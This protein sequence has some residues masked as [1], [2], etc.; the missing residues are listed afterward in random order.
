MLNLP[1]LMFRVLIFLLSAGLALTLGLP[2]KSQPTAL[3]LALEAQQLDRAGDLTQAAI[4]WQEAAS[5]FATEG[6]VQGRTKSLIN[7]SQVLQELGQ[8][9]RA[10][11]T[12][13][14][15]FDLENS[16]C[17]QTEQLDRFIQQYTERNSF[18]IVEGIGLRSLGNI[19]LHQGKLERSQKLL[20]LSVTAT[21][22][23]PELSQS[24]LALGNVHQALSNQTRDRWSYD[25]ITEIIDRQLP[26]NAIEPYLPA[27]QAYEAVDLSSICTANY[28]SPSTA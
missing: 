16:D 8:Y 2:V 6:D 24:L 23:S 13:L 25:R 17:S 14:S 5:K 9:P 10:C 20:D 27:V 22:D 11:D 3:T 1:R 7:Q 26:K 19:L 18:T 4:V 15:A 21:K 28:S 12:L